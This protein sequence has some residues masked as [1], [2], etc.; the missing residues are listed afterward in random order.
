MEPNREDWQRANNLKHL[1]ALDVPA[2]R[3]AYRELS[4]YN[5]M[6]SRMLDEIKKMASARNNT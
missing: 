5:Y 3:A 2:L 4:A 1:D 6:L